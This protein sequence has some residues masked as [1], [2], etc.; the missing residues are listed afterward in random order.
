MK[1]STRYAAFFATLLLA[2]ITCLSGCATTGMQRSE[3]TG[4]TMKTVES[5]IQQAVIQVNLT[6]SSLEDLIRPG[7]LDVKKSF[8]TY[9]KNVDTLENQGKRLF[10]H[11]DKMRAQGKEYFEEWQ[12][13]GNS[14]TNPEIQTLSEQRRA[15]L[16]AVYGNISDSSVGVKGAFKTYLTDIKEIRNYLLNDLTPK[17]IDTITPSAQKAIKD[18]DNLKDSI[19]PVLAAI[20]SAR[21]ELAQSGTK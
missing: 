16:G 10:Q 5:D 17:G 21:S 18:G 12:K 1:L 20:G 7:Q 13:Q 8:E 9:S 15:E 11:S 2:G 3:K 4:T 6:D 19:K 14:Y